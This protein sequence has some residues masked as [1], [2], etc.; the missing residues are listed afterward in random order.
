MNK[1]LRVNMTKLSVSTETVAEKYWLLGGRALTSRFV[2]DEVVPECNPLGRFNKLVIA[3]GLFGGSSAP[4]CG[5]LSVGAK[6][7]LTGGIKESNGGGTSA[8]KLARL[9]IKAIIIEG[10]P[11]SEGCYYILVLT[12]DKQELVL[13]P[14]F[15]LLGVYETAKRLQERY[16]KKAGIILIGPAGERMMTAA[17]ITNADVDGVPSRFCARGG[18]GAVMGS[19]GLK[20]I[21]IDD[22]GCTADVPLR[23]A[24]FAAAVRDL[25]EVIRTTP[26]T[27]EIYPK[28]G[29]AP[30]LRTTNSLGGL[31]TR[32]FTT[33]RFEKAEEICAEKLRKLILARG[34]KPTHGCMPG[35]FIRCSNVLPDKNG[36]PLVSPLEYETLGLIGSNCEIADLDQIAE[37]NRLCNDYGVDTVEI[38]G[39]IG[40]AMQAGLLQ[41]G[42]GE[43]AIELVKEIGKGSVL[44]RVIGQ[45]GVVTARVFGVVD[46]PAVKGQIMAAYEPR[47][48]KG[49]GVTYATSPM[50]ADHTA[51]ST[52]RANVDHRSREGQ[53]NA[54]RNAQICMA[55]YDAFGM[56]MFAGAAVKGRLELLVNLMNS[57]YG[58]KWTEEDLLEY[59]KV[60]LRTERLFNRKAGFTAVHDRL[61]EHFY[62]NTNPATGTVFDITGEELD[63]TLGDL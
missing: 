6:S 22:G 33:G 43:T 14:D 15:H 25:S 9:G 59:G 62:E 1:V 36:N 24:S 18:L 40:I 23:K 13:T 34:G 4:S 53:V 8:H 17:G 12:K 5:R 16:G 45:G 2:L 20:A 63:T 26:Q 31:P 48:I 29:T 21:V 60:T 52:I 3:P 35:C 28:F 56:C 50:G 46:V 54:S 41:F 37:I 10:K 32:N 11:E 55:V 61:P 27:A 30:M 51:G 47:A 58:T 19:K 7:P 57:F 44:G 39:A 42:D 38:G 49:F